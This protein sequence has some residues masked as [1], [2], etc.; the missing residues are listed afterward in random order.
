MATIEDFLKLEI[1][2][3][4]IIEVDDANTKKPM[5]KIT[6]DFG[7]EG[8]KQAIA[9]VK[10][11]YSKEELLGKEFAFVFNL[12]P[13]KICDVLSEC[14]IMAASDGEKV[15]VLQPEKELG[16]GAKVS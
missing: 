8:T 10:S 5:Y 2:I 12:E 13:K 16:V 6:V 11:Y 9:G 14:M 1:R 7:T 3:G 15:V 4:R